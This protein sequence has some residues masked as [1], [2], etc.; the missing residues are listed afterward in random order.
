L[1]NRDNIK[2]LKRKLNSK[3]TFNDEDIKKEWIAYQKYKS[4]EL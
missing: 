3:L 2:A 1:Y 4:D